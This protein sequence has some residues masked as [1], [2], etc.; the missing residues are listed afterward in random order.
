[1]YMPRG[2]GAAVPWL[3]RVSRMPMHPDSRQSWIVPRQGVGPQR[4]I[5]KRGLEIVRSRATPY[6]ADQVRKE[7]EL[8]RQ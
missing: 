7:R 1:M 5:S 6:T 3:V 2:C 8:Y 4:G